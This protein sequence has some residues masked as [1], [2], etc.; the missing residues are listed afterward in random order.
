MN[1]F[2]KAAKESKGAMRIVR[3][4][5]GQP[6]RGDTERVIPQSARKIQGLLGRCRICGKPLR[7]E[8]HIELGNVNGRNI[9]AHVRCLLEKSK[10]TKSFEHNANKFGE[11]VET[12]L[13]ILDLT[14]IR[15][16]VMRK[17]I[18]IGLCKEVIEFIM[19]NFWEILSDIESARNSATTR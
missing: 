8:P 10:N 7:G 5:N 19:K 4:F 12:S 13:T 2:K 9:C 18:E 6:Y 17:A 16:E 3:R 11:S 14:Q 1:A 15:K